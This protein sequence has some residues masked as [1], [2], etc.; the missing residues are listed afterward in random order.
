MAPR[1]PT[2]P[3]PPKPIQPYTSELRTM[4]ADISQIST[5]QAPIGTQPKPTVPPPPAPIQPAP[6][7][8]QVAPETPRPSVLPI[9]PIAPVAPRSSV[10]TPA[11]RIVIPSE[12][13]TSIS[14]TKKSVYIGLLAVIV[15]ALGAYFFL[16]SG[17]SNQE[18]I[19]TAT[20]SPSESSAP[21]GKALSVYFNQ[22]ATQT[23]DLKTAQT[24]QDDFLNIFNSTQ[25]SSQQALRIP[26]MGLFTASL[27]DF[28]TGIGMTVPADLKL[29][30]SSDWTVLSYGQSEQFDAQGQK[31]ADAAT[32]PR[33]VMISALQDATA[34]NQAMQNWETNGLASVTLD[35]VGFDKTKA[36]AP[37][38]S[39]GSYQ[40]ISMRYQNYPYADQSI[41]YAVMLASNGRN[42]LVISTSRE[43][44]F[45]VID[46]L[47]Q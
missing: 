4:K 32:K 10:P 7:P 40:Q 2:P 19:N 37:T 27:G 30:L 43:S 6:A 26:I 39:S 20:P 24:A 11:P 23:A 13:T 8:I 38:F 29:A 34:A 16:S 22:A 36:S 33:L 1:P 17:T 9:T 46:Q 14:G 21:L 25:P 45:Y 41:D 42:Y 31:V 5:G 12:T 28:L 3:T 18:V 35:I 47:I 44:M 15:L